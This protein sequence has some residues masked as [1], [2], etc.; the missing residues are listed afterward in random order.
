MLNCAKLD[1][2]AADRVTDPLARPTWARLL[3]R[4]G[5][6]GRPV[7]TKEIAAELG[8]HVNGVRRHLERLA[9]AGLLER[10][11]ARHGPGRPRDVWVLA[12]G[13]E[14]GPRR[15]PDLARWLA[16]A[17]PG[18][19]DTLERVERAGRG[20][21]RELAEDAPGAGARGFRDAVAALGFAPTIEA[22]GGGEV[23]CRLDNCPYATA[24]RENAAL[25]CTLHRGITAGLLERFAPGARL[26][27]WEPHDPERAGCRLGAVGTGWSEAE[28]AA[29]KR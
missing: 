7:T 26:V 8:L 13:A 18:D 4:I 19:N 25:I 29:A 24:A 3:A 2:M 15:Y 6:L 21:G 23:L 11:R 22:A 1:P 10:R 27:R 12:P 16:R 17:M 14:P 5:E 9:S 20:I 28:L